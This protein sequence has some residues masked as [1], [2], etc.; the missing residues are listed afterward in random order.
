MTPFVRIKAPADA[1]RNTVNAGTQPIQVI[2]KPEVVLVLPSLE[3]NLC[4][5]GRESAVSLRGCH[6]IFQNKEDEMMERSGLSVELNCLELTVASGV[7]AG[8]S[9][10]FF[11]LSRNSK[12]AFVQL[13]GLSIDGIKEA[14]SRTL[15]RSVPNLSPGPDWARPLAP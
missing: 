8:E 7:A 3:V 15:L 12:K 11:E 10:K 5:E 6:A 2:A 14:T 4:C 9:Q 1:T 13:M